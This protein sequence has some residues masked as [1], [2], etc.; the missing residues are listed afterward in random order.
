MSNHTIRKLQEEI[1]K[2]QNK[3]AILEKNR[4]YCGKCHK[5]FYSGAADS[6]IRCPYCIIKNLK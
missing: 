6:I 1:K 2:L 3:I 4:H 5:H